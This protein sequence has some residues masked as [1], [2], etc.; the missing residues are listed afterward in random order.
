MSD[1][2]RWFKRFRRPAPGAT[3]LLCLH[4]AGGNA[5]TFRQWPQLLPPSIDPVAVQLP[6]RADRFAEPRYHEMDKL[7]DDLVAAVEPLLDQQPV[8]FFGASMGA[9]VGWSLAH[10]LRERA[11]PMPRALY[12]S[13]SVAPSLDRQIRGW[14]GPDEGLVRYMREMGGTPS[15]LFED[16]GL[17]GEMVATLRAD[18]TVLSTHTYQPGVLLDIPITAFA[19]AADEE[20]P[21]R[22]M[23]PWG[24][25]TTGPFVLNVL[26]G[27]HFFGSDA[28]RQMIEMIVAGMR[29][30]GGD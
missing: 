9:R 12:V 11:M 1:G 30:A 28:V 10:A 15:Q 27:G 24:A 16:Q 3:I 29:R 7:V 2:R 4:H 18:L 23:E 20:S 14:N 17:L 8:A 5:A 25:E 26:D 22:R 19:G 6:G 13:A 21:A